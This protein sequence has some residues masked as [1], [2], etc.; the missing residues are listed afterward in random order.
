MPLYTVTNTRKMGSWSFIT[1]G[2]TKSV[3]AGETAEIEMTAV[4]AQN[5]EAP[6]I[7]IVK[8][9][10]KPAPARAESKGD[11]TPPTTEEP[12]P[13]TDVLAMAENKDV[14]Y[15]TF[16]SEAK[17]LLGDACPSGKAEIVAALQAMAGEAE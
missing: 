9:K 4:E 13:V 7:D 16:E 15:K 5:G 12:K 6:G 11:E 2:G 10:A 1:A 8:G 14:H 3:L 17:K